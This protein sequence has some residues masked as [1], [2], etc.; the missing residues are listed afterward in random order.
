MKSIKFHLLFLACQLITSAFAEQ[1]GIMADDLIRQ[2][3]MS[4]HH[5]DICDVAADIVNETP[6]KTLGTFLSN[7]DVVSLHS[8]VVEP[9]SKKDFDVLRIGLVRMPPEKYITMLK[10]VLTTEPVQRGKAKQLMHPFV[11]YNHLLADNWQHPDV[12]DIL[13]AAS[14]VF[15]SDAD[16]M[17]YLNSI[18]SGKAKQHADDYRKYSGDE[19]PKPVIL[20]P[21]DG[22]LKISNRNDP[23]REL[24]ATI[25]SSLFSKLVWAAVIA[26][27][28]SLLWLVFKY[29]K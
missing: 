7:I 27:V 5:G 2:I 14:T 22:K 28:I 23:M 9:R 13:T 17:S 20:H 18:R 11:N 21:Q 12:R 1:P 25:S 6:A 3:V 15:A 26:V 29:R 4:T 24:T 19:F 8:I 16:M 10:M